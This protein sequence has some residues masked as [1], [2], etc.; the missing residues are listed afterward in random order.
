MD[1]RARAGTNPPAVRARAHSLSTMRT[2]LAGSIGAFVV[3]VACV[4][5]GRIA[6]AQTQPPPTPAPLP[7]ESA[8][9]RF[10]SGQN[11]VPYFEGWIKNADGSFDL[12]FGYFNR[13]WQEE[14]II[15][16]GAENKIEPGNVERGQPT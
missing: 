10:N 16:P 14:L 4:G 5:A 2:I 9:I 3:A 8:Q 1:R 12:V 11:V 7:T 6:L 13:N 15:P